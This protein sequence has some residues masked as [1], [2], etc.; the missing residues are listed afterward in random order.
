MIFWLDAQLPPALAVFLKEQFNVE[1]F[2]LREIGLRD[3]DDIEIFEKAREQNVVL[4]SKDNDF[5]EMV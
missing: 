4:I 2:A 5:V 1:A 3:A